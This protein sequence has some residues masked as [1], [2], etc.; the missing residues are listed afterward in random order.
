VAISTKDVY[1]AAEQIRAAGGKITREPGAGA[2]VR[3]G[4][5]GLPA[6][7]LVVWAWLAGA[8]FCGVVLA[9]TS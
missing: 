2:C 6:R 4:R 3:V 5:E 7:L 1:K 9:A 8:E